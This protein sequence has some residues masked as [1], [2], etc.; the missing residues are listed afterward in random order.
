[1]AGGYLKKYFILYVFDPNKV[2]GIYQSVKYMKA[3]ET[4]TDNGFL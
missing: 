2:K 1:M 3:A 4:E